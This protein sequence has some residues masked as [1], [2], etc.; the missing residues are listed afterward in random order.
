MKNEVDLIGESF[1]NLGEN[2]VNILFNLQYNFDLHQTEDI[3]NYLNNT[4]EY[5]NNWEL[6]NV[7]HEYNAILLRNRVLGTNNIHYLKMEVK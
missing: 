3:I 2:W 7:G 4:S 5:Y 6:D 1:K